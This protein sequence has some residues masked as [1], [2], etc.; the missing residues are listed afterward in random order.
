MDTVPSDRLRSTEAALRAERHRLLRLQRSLGLHVGPTAGTQQQDTGELASFDQHAADTASDT[1][2]RE[3]D[4][5]LLQSFDDDLLEVDAALARLRAGTYGTCERC[6]EP[7]DEDRL[8]A[9][10]TA[11]RCLA[12]QEEAES[13][14]AASTLDGGRTVVDREAAAHLDLLPTEDTDDEDDL[15]VGAEEAA[16]HLQRPTG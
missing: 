1:L 8:R 5:A 12:H 7:I 13:L 4:A 6:G 14:R 16:V 2:E 15:D 9:L 3:I 11:V 10:P